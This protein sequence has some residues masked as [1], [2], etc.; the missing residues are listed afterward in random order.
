MSN[1]KTINYPGVLRAFNKVEECPEADNRIETLSL[2][3]KLI[4]QSIQK[5]LECIRTSNE[6]TC[7]RIA[8][9]EEEIKNVLIQLDKNNIVLYEGVS[10]MDA[11]IIKPHNIYARSMK[12]KSK[13]KKFKLN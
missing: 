3:S 4:D 2:L 6:S 11:L 9:S 10:N 8:V 7:K 1:T 5:E 13:R 12:V